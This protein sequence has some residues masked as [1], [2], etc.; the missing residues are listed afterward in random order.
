MINK[1]LSEKIGLITFPLIDLI[2]IIKLKVE[3]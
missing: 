3:A 2:V 1:T